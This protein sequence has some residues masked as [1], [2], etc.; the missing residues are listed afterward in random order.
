MVK[1]NRK[2]NNSTFLTI[3]GDTSSSNLRFLLQKS[4][5]YYIGKVPLKKSSNDKDRTLQTQITN[6]I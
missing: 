3:Q 5:N 2:E 1:F 4:A 6:N